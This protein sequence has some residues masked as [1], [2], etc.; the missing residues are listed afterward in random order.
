MIGS[1]SYAITY[2]SYRK[3]YEDADLVVLGKVVSVDN[4][5]KYRELRNGTWVTLEDS[6]SAGPTVSKHFFTFPVLE[7]EQVIKGELFSK[8]VTIIQGGVGI[9]AEKGIVYIILEDPPLEAG[10]RV[11]L[12][13]HKSK[14]EDYPSTYS[15]LGPFGR[16][17]VVDS[18]VYSMMYEAPGLKLLEKYG[19]PEQQRIEQAAILTRTEYAKVNGTPLE[20]FI[21]TLTAP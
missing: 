13:L 20:E 12:F 8:T 17:E 3:A 5:S 18:K 1:V 7:V 2:R 15:Y 21:E 11:I 16:F 9:D 10:E 4:D 19:I 6:E 14:D